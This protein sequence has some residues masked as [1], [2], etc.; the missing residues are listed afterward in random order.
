MKYESSRNSGQLEDKDSIQ[1]EKGKRE[2]RILSS[3]VSEATLFL[4]P[5]LLARL[6]LLIII[7]IIFAFIM[8][9]LNNKS[10]NNGRQ[11]LNRWV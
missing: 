2:R 5:F 8:Y 1:R 11:I 7:I 4:L 3:I 10:N 9:F 6:L